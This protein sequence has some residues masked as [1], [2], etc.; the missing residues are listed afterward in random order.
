MIVAD[1]NQTRLKGGQRFPLKKLTSV[2]KACS[3][4]LK[5]KKEVTISIAFISEKDMKRLN[6]TWRNKDR[7]TDVLSFGSDQKNEVYKGEILLNYEQA[8]RQAKEMNHSISDEVAFLM[9]HGVL[10]LFGYDHES[11]KD[12]K[13]M[14]PLQEKILDSLNIDSRL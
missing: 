6:A 9:V 2:L 10:H 4:Q 3:D 14:F 5:L 8:R 1:L 7:V 13:K 12:A 11:P